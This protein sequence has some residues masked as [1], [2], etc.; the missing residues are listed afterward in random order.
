MDPSTATILVA[1][2]GGRTGGAV[3]EV[4]L[5]AGIELRAFVHSNDDAE[6]LRERG[7][8]DVLVGDC[9]VRDDVARAVE[10][11]DILVCTVGSSPGLRQ[12]TGSDVVDGAGVERLVDAAS[13]AEVGHFVLVSSLGVG[14]S[15]RG[16]PMPFRILLSR[17]LDAKAGGE[18]HLQQSGLTYTIF[19]PGGLSSDPPTRDVLVGEGGESVTG[20][21]PRGDLARLL[22]AA[23]F[24]PEAANRTF[25]VVAR[26]RTRTTPKRV[27]DVDWH[28]PEPIFTG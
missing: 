28:V 24:T 27:V 22:V 13:E 8:E 6:R 2:A 3:V 14:N 9:L 12:V 21:I 5:D 10:G 23:A 11:V 18:T 26:D 16:M 25:E 20:S 19:R 7:V 4:L 15:R 1:G 17:I